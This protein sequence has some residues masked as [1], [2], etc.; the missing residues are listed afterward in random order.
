MRTVPPLAPEASIS[1][2]RTVT[3][4][5]VKSIAP[6][7]PPLPLAASVPD[8]ERS[9]MPM[10]E[11]FPPVLPLAESLP[12]TLTDRPLMAIRPP[13]V[14]AAAIGGKPSRDADAAAGAAIDDDAAVMRANR[15][16]ADRA[17]YVD[18][19]T[20]NIGRSRSA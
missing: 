10:T 6:P 3:S 18:G 11:I 1:A 20:Q 12:L 2:P 17:R 8:S 7:L 19:I 5:P 4:A 15:V 13:V 9:P 14:P 16:G